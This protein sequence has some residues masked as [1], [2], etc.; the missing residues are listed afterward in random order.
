MKKESN[1]IVTQIYGVS[2]VFFNK[3]DARYEGFNSVVILFDYSI[4]H[5]YG[6]VNLEFAITSFLDFSQ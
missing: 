3:V 6:E 5:T 1:G 4:S 2:A